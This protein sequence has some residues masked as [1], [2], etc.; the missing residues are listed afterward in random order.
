MRNLTLM[1]VLSALVFGGCAN[2]NVGER[3]IEVS[4]DEVPAAVK[5]T[6]LRESAGGKI[7]EIEKELDEGTWIYV[8]DIRLA[9]KRWEYEIAAD[10]KLIE[11]ELDNEDDGEDDDDAKVKKDD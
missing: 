6:L 8:V 1:A 3:E 11:K 5:E 7:E 4:I 10:G 9:G 2:R